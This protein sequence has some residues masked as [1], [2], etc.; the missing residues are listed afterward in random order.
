LT[1]WKSAIVSTSAP[2][3]G[4]R[5]TQYCFSVRS[6][7]FG[8]STSAWSAEKCAAFP[9][10][11]RSFARS[12]GWIAASG[13]AHTYG[14]YLRTSKKGKT[15][16]RARVPAGRAT[17]VVAKAPGYGGLAVS[18]NGVVVKRVSLASKTP[19]AKVLVAL[20]RVSRATKIVITTTRAKQVRVDAIVLARK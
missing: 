11:D 15:L 12:R 8:A 17:L 3:P 9:L 14:T 5:G 10:D 2:F 13:A 20:P 4:T 6:R 1:T 18:Y 7:D 19:R 16:T